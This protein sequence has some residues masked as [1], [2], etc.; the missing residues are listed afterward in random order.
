MSRDVVTP[1]A[2]DCQPVSQ[3]AGRA[4][5]IPD[6]PEIFLKDDDVG[7]DAGT[8]DQQDRLKITADHQVNEA[9]A[10]AVHQF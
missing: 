6:L 2:G 8:G 4:A 1:R 9:E 5:D 7:K 3:S 10:W